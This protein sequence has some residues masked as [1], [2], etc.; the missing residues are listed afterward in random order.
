[1]PL[2]SVRV[3]KKIGKCKTDT[4]HLTQLV[5]IRFGD[6]VRSIRKELSLT[7]KQVGEVFG[8][9]RQRIEQIENGVSNPKNPDNPNKYGL[10]IGTLYKICITLGVEPVDVLPTLKE[11]KDIPEFQ[12][13]KK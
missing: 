6:K 1:M 3:K 5:S 12:V 7:Q 9:T 8:V 2:K 10:T 13:I 4:G 11:L